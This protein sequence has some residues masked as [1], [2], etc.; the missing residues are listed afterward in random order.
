M[1]QAGSKQLKQL[2][3]AL[4]YLPLQGES[5]I[6]IVP[7]DTGCKQLLVEGQGQREIL[8]PSSR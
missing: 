7:V 1:L 8:L 5:D 4:P 2:S 6:R 3:A